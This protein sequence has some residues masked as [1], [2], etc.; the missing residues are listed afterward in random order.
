MIREES[1]RF[2]AQ[3]NRQGRDV[4]RPPRYKKP[5]WRPHGSYIV[6]IIRDFH[7]VPFQRMFIVHTGEVSMSPEDMPGYRGRIR[8]IYRLHQTQECVRNSPYN[9]LYSKN[10]RWRPI[11]R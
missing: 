10:R 9:T 4:S 1:I 11:Y 3:L 7:A 8:C 2:H 5:V 6:I